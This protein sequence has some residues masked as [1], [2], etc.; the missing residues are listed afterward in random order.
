MS[1]AGYPNWAICLNIFIFVQA[2]YTFLFYSFVYLVCRFIFLL[3]VG[4]GDL[5]TRQAVACVAEV[6]NFTSSFLPHL[7]RHVRPLRPRSVAFH[8]R[9]FLHVDK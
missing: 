5:G 2:C 3:S 7:L 4:V 1:G 6:R 9:Y 8:V